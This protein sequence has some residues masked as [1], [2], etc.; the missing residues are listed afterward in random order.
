MLMSHPGSFAKRIDIY[1]TIGIKEFENLV[2]VRLK[3]PQ[4]YYGNTLLLWNGKYTQDSIAYRIIKQ[5]C[6][7]N[8]IQNSNDQVWLV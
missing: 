1:K 5:S 3:D 4:K 2:K 6:I 8:N 7:N